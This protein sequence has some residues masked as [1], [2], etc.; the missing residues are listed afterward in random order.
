M[1]PSL[2]HTTQNTMM[3]C[4]RHHMEFDAHLFDVRCID[5]ERGADGP[6]EVVYR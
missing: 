6:V 5:P 3:A 4:K 1:D 2:R